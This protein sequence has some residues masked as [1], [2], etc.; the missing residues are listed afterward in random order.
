MSKSHLCALE[1][2]LARKGWRVVAVYPGN[3]YDI[4][5]TWEIRR[6]ASA[7]SLFIDFDGLM[8]DGDGCLPL[9]KSYGCMLRNRSSIGLYFRRVNKSREH[10]E[11]DLTQ[12]MRALDDY[13]A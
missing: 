9:E 8:L 12:F 7:P 11:Q 6:N 1:T 4:A 2:A 10:W 5:S 13:D 3:D